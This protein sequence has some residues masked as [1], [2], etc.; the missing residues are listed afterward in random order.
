M[1]LVIRATRACTP[2]WAAWALERTTRVFEKTVPYTCTDSECGRTVW[3]D[4]ADAERALAWLVNDNR[5]PMN[6]GI[7]FEIVE[8]A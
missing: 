8:V 2:G 7:D 4:R 5:R 6:T 1:K 3:T